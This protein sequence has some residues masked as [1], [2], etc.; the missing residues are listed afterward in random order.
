MKNINKEIKFKNLVQLQKHFSNKQR[1]VEHLEGLRWGA[2]RCCVHCGSVKTYVCK[3]FGKYK[4]AD[5]KLRF[6]VTTGTF[7]ENTK[8]PLTKWFVAMYLCLSHKKGVS[9]CQLARDL[10]VTQ[11]TAWFILHRVRQLVVSKAPQMLLEGMV[12]VD[13]S[14][15]GGLEKNKHKNKRLKTKGA[16]INK[17]KKVL[18]GAVERNGRAV[19]KFIERPTKEHLLPFIKKNIKPL[20]TVYTDE[21]YA[22]GQ[23]SD[24][25]N[26]ASI[27][28]SA[29]QYVRG[30]VHTN[31][32]ENFWSVFKRCIHGTYHQVSDKHIQQYANEITFRF[33]TR[34]Q[35]EQRRFDNAL[36]NCDGRLTYADLIQSDK[37]II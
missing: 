7:F 18:V 2:E 31:T 36:G 17:G 32:I 22:Y 15:L 33:S 8:V 23:L 24:S 3:G 27:N 35:S 19:V 1:C 37:A 21:F 12:E 9:S 4:C 28:H 13:E 30:N 25:F 10:G 6:S 11:K 16:T 29:K 26:H 20:T 5:C 14:Y 34:E